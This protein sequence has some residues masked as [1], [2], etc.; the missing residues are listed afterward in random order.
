MMRATKE[1][2][3]LERMKLVM[4]GDVGGGMIDIASSEGGFDIR[5]YI[6][7]PS[8]TRK[9]KESQ[10]FFVN[11]RYVQSKVISDAV[12]DGYKSLLERGRYPSA[13][14]FVSVDPR[15]IDVNVHPTKLLVK[16]E[17]EKEIREKIIKAIKGTFDE[18][19]RVPPV[20]G[21][22]FSVN[23][24][25]AVRSESVVAKQAEIQPEFALEERED[26]Y[27]GPLMQARQAGFESFLS[28]SGPK[29]F[30][31][32]DLYI[33]EMKDD[34]I[35]VTD[36]HAAHERI[37]Y[38][39]FSKAVRE[40]TRE[41]Q[42]LLFPARLDL[43]A[44]EAVLM[45][46]LAD[47]FRMLGFNI[48]PFGKNS[49]VIESAPAILKD[50]DVKTVIYDVLNEIASSDSP[51]ADPLEEMIKMT[52]C[53]AAIKSGDKLEGREMLS[54]L[55]KLAHCE[56]PFTCPHGR[57]TSFDITLDELEKRFRRK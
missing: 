44:S 22:V 39:Y 51:K 56:L 13:V 30:Q 16:F 2:N 24:Q 55:D 21:Q 5:G 46:K 23:A 20:A 33:I 32:G 1:M 36:Q 29:I 40:S 18:V 7:A 25:G 8:F 57:P 11:K 27:G 45:D 48:E 42:N 41:V 31:F 37:L 3:L 14:L 52:S 53:R 34:K 35:T 6:S 26:K 10:V 47:K 50:S 38:E 43:S 4:G 28:A 15:N 9:D 19:K 49:Y 54:L 12:Y 17:N